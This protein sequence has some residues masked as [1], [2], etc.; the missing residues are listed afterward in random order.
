MIKG[1][2]RRNL[3]AGLAFL[4]P[5]IF[6]FLAFTL[7]PLVL[8]MVLAFSNADVREQNRFRDE[9][10]RF[11]G[12]ENFTQMLA[13]RDFW[14]YLG[15]TL[16]M[17]LSIPF[18]IAA[19]LGAALLLHRSLSAHRGWWTRGALL[20][21]AGGLMLLLLAT[22][23]RG[24]MLVIGGVTA[25]ILALGAIGGLSVYRT[26]FYLPSFTAGV[27]IYILWTKLYNPVS[28]PINASLQPLL[29][30][31][32]SATNAMPAWL[33][34]TGMYFLLA[35]MLALFWLTARYLHQAW[36]DGDL[37]TG[38]AVA[39]VGALIFPA[40]MAPLVLASQVAA[41]IL[42]LAVAF[43]VAWHVG[44]AARERP[45]ACRAFSGLGSGFMLVSGSLT[46]QLVLLGL[47]AV[48]YKL[49]AMARDGLDPPGWL[50]DYHF[51]KPAIMIVGLW[52]AVG[53]NNMLLYLAALSNVSQDLYEA[54]E[55]D[56][57]GRLAK[58]WNVT[59]PQI[60]PTTFFIVVISVIGGLQGGF[61]SARSMTNGGPA[62]STTTLSYYIYSE[63][64]LSGHMGYAS[65]IA[66]VMFLIILVITLF[67]WKFGS[68]YVND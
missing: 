63:G 19:S 18:G 3:A 37:G 66:W 2:E 8:S 65:S 60:A 7:V 35:L 50:S 5:N 41:I 38:A 43:I 27:A 40:A 9:P 29:S 45:F 14:R 64:F 42:I 23:A 52:A 6:G 13:Q 68:Q 15:N 32:A 10:L 17:M 36:R 48:V 57:A 28:G 31:L 4:A 1:K 25:I 51:A 59:W 54:A 11:V 55:L 30:G 49:P 20:T 61:D 39:V 44:Q 67:N 24:P 53:S 26:L 12:L 34:Q 21:F 16:F 46:A 62:G 33:V 56:G 22:G 47:G 58:F